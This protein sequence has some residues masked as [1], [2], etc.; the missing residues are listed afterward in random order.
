MHDP[1]HPMD[2]LW[3]NYA[4]GWLQVICMDRRSVWTE[5]AEQ[6]GPDLTVPC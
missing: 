6:Y 1:S 2:A 4:M 3:P 5:D